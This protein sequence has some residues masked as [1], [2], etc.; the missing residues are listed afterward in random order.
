V[1]DIG[2][3]SSLQPV[4]RHIPSGAQ[5]ARVRRQGQQNHVGHSGDPSGKTIA[6]FDTTRVHVVGIAPA[7][8]VTSAVGRKRYL[9]SG[10]P[11]SLEEVPGPMRGAI[12]GALVFEGEAPDLEGAARLLRAGD[13]EISP[14]HDVG[15]VGAMA[16][17]I[18]PTMPVIV[19]E[20]G[21][22]RIAFSPIN[23]GLGKALRFGSNDAE[24]IERLGWLRHSFAP[25]ADRAIRG[26]GEIDLTEFQAEGLRRG[27]ECHNRNVASTAALL[28]RLAPQFIRHARKG[29]DPARAIE[30]A[31]SNPHF[32]LPFSMASC[33]A[34]ADAG[35]GVEGSSVVTAMA[36]NGR[37]LGIRVSGLKDRWFLAPAPVGN[38]K[39]FPGFSID[40]AQPTMGDSFI[41]ETV[42]LGAFAL[43]ASPAICSFVGGDPA[44]AHESVAEMRKLCVGS[45]SRFLLPFERF[46]GTPVGIDVRKVAETGI[47]PLTN[48][49][50][51]HREPGRGQ[52][53]AGLTRLPLD[54]FVEASRV[55]DVQRRPSSEVLR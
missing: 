14:C 44:R 37:R 39:L 34:M 31:S 43:S 23:E 28:I 16:G 8:E 40:D 32:F 7:S 51:A 20:T 46:A 30:Y 52:V 49:G 47:A 38:P 15:A 22:G 5:P 2:G 13:V 35:H 10:P 24:T 55:L 9:H 27:D 48:N 11:I 6:A 4:T 25:L 3:G 17:I 26:D 29:D 19:V 50:L 18:T 42:G 53:G 12:L 45:S 41:T 36:G 33:K 54:P 21:A 1:I